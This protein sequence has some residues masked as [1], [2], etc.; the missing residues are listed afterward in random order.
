MTTQHRR[1]WPLWAIAALWVTAPLSVAMAQEEATPPEPIA[2]TDSTGSTGEP[3]FSRVI[4]NEET[5]YAIQR[6]AFLIKDKIELSLMYSNLVGDRFVTTSDSFALAGSASY[7]LSEQFALELFGGWFNPTISE[8]TEELF[9]FNGLVAEDAKL[10]QL[11]WAAGL[12]FQW[13]PIYGKLELFDYS[14][15]NF[16]FYFGAGAGVGQ[17]RVR[18]FAGQEL[19]PTNFD[20]GDS[21]PIEPNDGV[22]SFAPDQTHF[23]GSFSAGVR[24]RFLSWLGLKAEIRDYIYTSRVFRADNVPSSTDTVRNNLFLQIGATFLLGGSQN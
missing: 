24:F 11:L 17:S 23:V 13:S 15:G 7:H 9:R 20:P 3:G 2:E 14:L 21:C 12:G 22:L 19:D 6:K 5:I 4:D 18:C 16:A 1:P 8:S 10:T